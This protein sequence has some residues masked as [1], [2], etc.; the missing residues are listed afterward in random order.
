M[1]FFVGFS[2]KKWKQCFVLLYTESA[3]LQYSVNWLH[4]FQNSRRIIH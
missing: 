4:I 1:L 3:I 2:A